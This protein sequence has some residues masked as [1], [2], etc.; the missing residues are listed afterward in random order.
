MTFFIE[1]L[2]GEAKKVNSTLCLAACEV[3][4]NKHNKDSRTPLRGSLLFS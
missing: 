1:E 2:C 3:R 4:A